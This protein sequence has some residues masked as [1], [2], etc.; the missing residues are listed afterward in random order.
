MTLRLEQK[1]Y[2]EMNLKILE[3][4]E[5]MGTHRHVDFMCL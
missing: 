4:P 1:P 3:L 2:A 5:T